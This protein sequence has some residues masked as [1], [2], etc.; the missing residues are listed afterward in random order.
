MSQA[1]RPENDHAGE[2][3]QGPW[4]D[5]SGHSFALVH[6]LALV[7]Q[8]RCFR[9]SGSYLLIIRLPTSDSAYGADPLMTADLSA[10]TYRPGPI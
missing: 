3:H 9:G 7:G 1:G 4:Q 10:E 5:S 8:K 2:F 6:S